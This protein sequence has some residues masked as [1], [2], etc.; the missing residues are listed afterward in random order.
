MSSCDLCGKESELFVANIEGSIVHSCKNCCRFGNVIGK[1]EEFKS[2]IKIKKY[3][4]KENTETLIENYS[5]IIRKE[6]NRKGLKQDELAMKLNVKESIIHK[7]ENGQMVPSLDIA[8]KIEKFFGI[9]LIENIP[10]IKI[11]L[12]HSEMKGFTLGDIIK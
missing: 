12:E 4:E 9:K 7:I 10:D 5:E 1:F 2:E 3:A 8:R 6:R 11:N